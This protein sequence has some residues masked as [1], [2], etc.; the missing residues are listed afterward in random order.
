[1]LSG[2]IHRSWNTINGSDLIEGTYRGVNFIFS[3]LHLEQVTTD[4]KGSEKRVTKFKGQWLTLSLAKPMT[5]GVQL[6]GRK[7]R[8]GQ[9]TVETESAEFNSRFQ[10]IASD[11]HTA[12]YVLTPQLIEQIIKADKKASARMLISFDGDKMHVAIDSYRELFEPA[13]KKL[14]AVS[15]IATLRMQMKWDVNYI[16]NIIDEFLANEALFNAEGV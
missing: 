10:I 3:N 8:T 5:F 16:A 12:F 15:N 2:L 13:D 1:M 7:G 6:R 14:F 9:S 11:A 4:N